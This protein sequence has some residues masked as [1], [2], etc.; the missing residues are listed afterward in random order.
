VGQRVYSIGNPFGLAEGDIILSLSNIE[1]R[2]VEDLVGQIHNRKVDESVRIFA[3]R[4]SHERYFDLNLKQN[5]V[6]SEAERKSE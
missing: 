5:T 2:S 4:D 6:K 1:I 3:L